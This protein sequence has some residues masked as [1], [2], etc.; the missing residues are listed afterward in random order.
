MQRETSKSPL[1]DLN[2]N[3]AAVALT[4]LC[5]FSHG[6][7]N[8]SQPSEAFQCCSNATPSFA[9]FVS[10]AFWSRPLPRLR[11]AETQAP[12]GAQL[13]ILQEL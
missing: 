5:D 2:P 1:A 11:K 8:F 3:D 12:C 9:F 10:R 4:T 13:L 6:V 7:R